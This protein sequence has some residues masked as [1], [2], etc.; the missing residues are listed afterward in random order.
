MLANTTVETVMS[1]EVTPLFTYHRSSALPDSTCQYASSVYAVADHEV[2]STVV[3]ASGLI[4]VSIAHAIG[5]AHSTASAAS[6]VRQVA[7][8]RRVDQSCV[9]R[10]VPV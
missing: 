9:A 10:R 7:L 4:E 8:K 3:S 5:T 6:T 1:A 2:G